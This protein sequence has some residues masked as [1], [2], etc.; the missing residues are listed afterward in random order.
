MP[1]QPDL[2]GHLLV[3]GRA[4][5]RD[6]TRRGGGQ[7]KVRPVD[8]ESH[9]Q[10]IYG[11]AGDA[12]IDRPVEPSL[13]DQQL[14][15][16]GTVIT[17]EGAAGFDLKL[18]SLEQRSRHKIGPRP[19]WLLLTVHPAN[20]NRPER[21]QV[22]VSDEY[23]GNFLELFE[24]YVNEEH[25]RSGK[26]KNAALVAN[27]ARIR[28][29]VL[30]D[31][32]QSSNEPPAAGREW[33]EIWL[34][35]EPDAIH[36][37]RRYAEVLGL[38]FAEDSIHFDSRYVVWIEARWDDLSTLA[39][40]AVP[41]T[42]IRRPS[43]IDTVEDLE[44]DERYEYVDDLSDRVI[45]AGAEAPAVCLVDTGVRRTH[46]LLRPALGPSSLLAVVAGPPS[47][48]DGHGTKMA[49]LALLGPLDGLL[50]SDLHT[51]LLHGLESVKI[52]P[53]SHSNAHAPELYGI[54][55][56]QAVAAPEAANGSRRRVFSMPITCAPDRPGE[57][58]LW[59]ASVDALAAGTDI[60]RTANTIELLGPPDDAAKRLILVSAGNVAGCMDDYV[61]MCDVSPIEDP[62]QAWN[63]LTVGA[64]TGLVNIPS[65]PS[66]V[67]WR[68][69][70]SAGDISPYSRT[71]VAA[72][73]HQW[74]IKPDICMEGGN[75]LT[76]GSGDFNRG[77][78]VVSLR[79][80]DARDDR[81]LSSA[82]ATSAATSQAARLA[83]RAMAT[84]PDFWPETIRGLLVH[85][86][87]WT[88]LM[89]S[90][91]NTETSKNA[92]RRLLRR[93]GWGVP[94]DTGVRSSARNAVTM[95]VQD[96]FAPFVGRDHRMRHFRLHELPWPTQ[97]L[98]A[99]GEADVELRIT[100]SYLIEPSPS[101]R[102]WQKRYAYASH[103]L[104]F[105]L[106]APNESLDG[107]VRRVNREA[108]LEEGGAREGSRSPDRWILGS[109]QRNRGSLHQDIWQGHGA[110][111][112]TTPTIA[113]H[114]VGGWWKNNRRADREDLPIR[115]ALLVSLRTREQTVDL[116]T[117][118]A[119]SLQVPVEAVTVET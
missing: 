90:A 105:E 7:P 49:G 50:A 119:V 60:G 77:H 108:A 81:A 69:L 31:L 38:R 72:G 17:I 63:A 78:P 20:E 3:I 35:P 73:G 98:L 16:L 111:L 66:F 37:A 8:R 68:A 21:A 86:A 19:K 10:R 104:R 33:W 61:S 39:F 102:G 92:R 76:D 41:V 106:Q 36:L 110:E 2:L 84:Y 59:S 62:A 14:K 99:L 28:S 112:A 82:N 88:P 56:A 67:E 25:A 11:E 64:Y 116:Y 43:L 96:S 91:V 18:E 75:V 52:I 32:W 107:F 101:R 13:S 85:A 89:K 53:D 15:A 42:E 71:G 65:D 40:S 48:Q 79:T 45:Y 74:P 34:R 44:Q 26:P 27:I 58:S 117:P 113:V 46:L 6:F 70:A 118:I 109:N 54:V 83:A 23:R 93:F 22:W 55:T 5:D 30:R 24:R 80:T 87:E 47:D 51:T 100:L 29:S 4:E 57:P 12:L 97:E 103:G 9:G 1:D 114:A 95:V 94:D 115:Y